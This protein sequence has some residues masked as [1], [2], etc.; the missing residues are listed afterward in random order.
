MLTPLPASAWDQDAAAHLVLRAGFGPRSADELEALAILGPERAVETFLSVPAEDQDPPVPLPDLTPDHFSAL[1]AQIRSSADPLEKR[2][3]QKQK[4]QEA[5]FQIEELTRWWIERMVQT[6]SP[7]VEKMAFFWHGHFATSMEKVGSPYKMWKQNQTFRR[8]ALGSFRD[9]VK[10]VSRDPAML[11]WL[12]L[13]GSRKERPNENFA[14]ELMELFTLGEGHYSEQDVKESARAFTGYRINPADQ[15]FRFMP[16]QFDGGPKT[17]LGQTGTWDGDQVIDIILNQ[18]ACARFLAAKLWSFFVN[19]SPAPDLI[20]RL[21]GELHRNNFE[22]RPVL[23]VIFRSAEF[24]A[25]A[26]RNS[27][28]KSPVQWIAQTCRTISLQ[29]PDAEVLSNALRQLGQLPFY[30][31]NVKGWEN[32]TA[33]INTATLGFRYAF[34]R[35]LVL[36]RLAPKPPEFMMQLPPMVGG[37]SGMGVV[38]SS[39]PRPAVRPIA[40][41]DVTA[42]VTRQEHAEPAALVKDLCRRLFPDRPPAP[43]EEQCLGL[44]AGKPLPLSDQAIRE[45]VALMVATPNFQLC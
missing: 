1:E 30:P 12:D 33:W 7:L 9:L 5:H 34:G 41:L 14:R 39:Q 22:L 18:P 8:Y 2:E 26:C 37:Q 42:L 31:P 10:A 27:Q 40:P 13:N 21:A 43:L 36:G 23:R 44:V 4:R 32:G 29:V 45:L 19:D 28:I 3:L 25:D 24:Y 20:D 6:P 16:G 17:F 11:V 35:Q 15:S 38:V